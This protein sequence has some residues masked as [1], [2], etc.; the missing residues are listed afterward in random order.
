[1]AYIA[2]MVV[3]VVS[4]LVAYAVGGVLGAF[5][6]AATIFVVTVLWLRSRLTIPSAPTPYPLDPIGEDPRKRFGSF[7][8]TEA[9]LLGA[10]TSRRIYD[11]SIKPRLLRVAVALLSQ[12]YAS[13]AADA[14]AVRDL[15]GDELWFVVDPSV[16]SD[17]EDPRV[18]PRDLSRVLE[19]IE[20]LSTTQEQP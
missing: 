7:A 3:A 15:V 19:M 8:S 4:T 5:V 13:R 2:L 14:S 18:D 6:V 20:S 11:H 1:M 9:Q 17:V 10:L 16:M 12:R